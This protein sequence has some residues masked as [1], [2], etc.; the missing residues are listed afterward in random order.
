[1][2]GDRRGPDV[3]RSPELDAA[4]GERVSLH[5]PSGGG[6]TILLGLI[7]GELTPRCGGVDVLGHRLHRARGATR[8]RFRIARTGCLFY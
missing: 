3:R 4:R 2:F 8:D 5:G 6:K 7:A 1:M